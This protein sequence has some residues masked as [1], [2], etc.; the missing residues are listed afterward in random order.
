MIVRIDQV[1]LGDKVAISIDGYRSCRDY[2]LSYHTIEVCV[3]AKHK[4]DMI[5]VGWNR[6]QFK[7][8]PYGYANIADT[9]WEPNKSLLEVYIDI[10]KYEQYVWTNAHLMVKLVEPLIKHPNQK[11]I[12]CNLP[13]PHADPNKAGEFVCVSCALLGTL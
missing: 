6:A 5:A 3:I 12:G 2:S 13:A 8:V 9:H 7:R 10:H 1:A 11:C 4:D